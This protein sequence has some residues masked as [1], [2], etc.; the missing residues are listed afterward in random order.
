MPRWLGRVLKRIHELTEARRVRFTLKALHELA[1]L[2][3]VVDDA[4]EALH[5]LRAADSA[6]RLL[7]E[8]TGEWMYVFKPALEDTEV[9][10]K[11]ILRGNCIVVSFHEDQEDTHDDQD[12]T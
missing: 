1:A 10:L 3:L 12:E 6:G 4:L 9:Y 11:L 7:S 8:H 2:E 5:G